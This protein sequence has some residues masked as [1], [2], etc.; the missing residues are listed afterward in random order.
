M[1]AE[2]KATEEAQ[3]AEKA[4]TAE[5]AQAG[6]EARSAEVAKMAAAGKAATEAHAAAVE[7]DAHGCMGSG[8][9]MKDSGGSGRRPAEDGP[10]KRLFRAL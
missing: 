8:I 4:E 6:E 10:P 3:A 7:E 2:A 5:E 9:Q 1:A